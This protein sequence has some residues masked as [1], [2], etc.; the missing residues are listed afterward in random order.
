MQSNKTLY[1]FQSGLLTII[2][3]KLNAKD[4]VL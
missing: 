4:M 2:G 3:E 1:Y